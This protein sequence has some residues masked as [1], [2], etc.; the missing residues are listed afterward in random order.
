M[1]VANAVRA[2]RPNAV[3]GT[4]AQSGSP[5][6]T[7]TTST[8]HLLAASNQVFLECADAT[9]PTAR[10]ALTTGTYTVATVTDSTHYTINAPGWMTGTYSQTGTTITV[11]M[12]GHW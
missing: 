11:T 3:S 5:T 12:S 9:S 8:P 7:V 4:Y 1:R 10:P 2:L 6:V